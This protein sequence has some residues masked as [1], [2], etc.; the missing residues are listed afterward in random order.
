MIRNQIKN[1]FKPEQET[2]HYKLDFKV[3]KRVIE[4]E[5]NRKSSFL[6]FN[7]SKGTFIG[8]NGFKLQYK[9]F[10]YGNFINDHYCF[11]TIIEITK[12]KTTV[13]LK[14]NVYT[15]DTIIGCVIFILG[16]VFLLFKI[17]TASFTEILSML[18]F[19]LV[20]PFIFTKTSQTINYALIMLFKDNFDPLLKEKENRTSQRHQN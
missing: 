15:K 4:E 13:K 20:V 12:G 9:R 7:N 19:A 16:C 6:D 18:F 14:T 3:V 10:N 11:G 5:F 1:L 2:F 8:S 17:W